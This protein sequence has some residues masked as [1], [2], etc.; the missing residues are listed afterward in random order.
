[1]FW[2][3]EDTQHEIAFFC[4]VVRELPLGIEPDSTEILIEAATAFI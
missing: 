1:L 3:P 2:A 4:A